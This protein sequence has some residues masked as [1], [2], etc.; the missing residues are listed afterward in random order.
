MLTSLH[1]ITHKVTTAKT[2][3][4]WK[5]ILS[6]TCSSQSC[7]IHLAGSLPCGER[8]HKGNSTTVPKFL[9]ASGVLWRVY[10]QETSLRNKPDRKKRALQDCGRGCTRRA[11]GDEACIKG[12][13]MSQSPI[14]SAAGSPAKVWICMKKRAEFR[15][16]LV[17]SGEED[18]LR[19]LSKETLCM[20]TNRKLLTK[21]LFEFD[22]KEVTKYPQAP[23]FL[24][25]EMKKKVGTFPWHRGQRLVSAACLQPRWKWSYAE[26]LQ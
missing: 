26:D 22:K 19:M 23:A 20:S 6:P 18:W 15:N 7:P 3:K 11:R 21:S 25:R 12:P 4:G 5:L 1:Y 17:G 14:L 16:C 10:V 2:L 9:P 8:R 13:E 24:L